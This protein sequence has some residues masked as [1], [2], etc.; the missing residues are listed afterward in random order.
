MFC[1]ERLDCLKKKQVTNRK[2]SGP[3]QGLKGEDVSIQGEKLLWFLTYVR[4]CI[5]NCWWPPRPFPQNP[6]YG[7]IKALTLS[8]WSG[9]RY[10]QRWMKPTLSSSAFLI[11]PHQPE[12]HFPEEC[13]WLERSIIESRKDSC[14]STCK[15][16]IIL[17]TWYKNKVKYNW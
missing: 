3:W 7:N 10:S 16:T 13:V 15:F 4:K 2:C 1:S 12:G 9:K 8:E 14:L 17:C 11:H 5:L 6:F